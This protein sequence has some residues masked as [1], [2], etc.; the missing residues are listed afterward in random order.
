MNHPLQ[1]HGVLR[2]AQQ[3]YLLALSP[4]LPS[5]SIRARCVDYMQLG[6]APR[7]QAARELLRDLLQS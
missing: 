6:C 7:A 1:E 3:R 4:R 5:E 2:C